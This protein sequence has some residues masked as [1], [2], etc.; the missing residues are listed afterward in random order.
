MDKDEKDY[1]NKYGS[2][3]KNLAERMDIL[4][5]NG[6]GSY[7]GRIME[8]INKVM[9]IEWKTIYIVINLVPKA[10]PRPR[11]SR[12]THAFYVKG[13]SDNRRRFRKFMDE[14]NL[15]M[16]TTPTKIKITSYL[17]IPSG[18]NRAEKVLAELHLVRPISK[19]DW[20]NLAKTYSDMIQERLLLDDA[21]IIEGESKK[22][23]SI[24]PRVEVEISY[25]ADYDSS[26]NRRKINKMIGKE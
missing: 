16:I 14:E 4:L 17:P 8:E 21:L 5:Q 7:R 13:A 6:L 9:N 25:M 3:P 19:P 22:F 10:T 24:R 15:E 2:I 23:Y 18:M 26:Y 12:F 11:Y 20:D 1:A